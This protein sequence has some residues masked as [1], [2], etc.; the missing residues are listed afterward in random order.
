MSM[1]LYNI[2]YRGPYEYD[3]FI[4]NIFQLNNEIKRLQKEFNDTS[5]SQLLLKQKELNDIFNELT[6]EDNELDRLLSIKER[7]YD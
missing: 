2:R 3:K 4:L 1:I 6:K 7:L 5:L